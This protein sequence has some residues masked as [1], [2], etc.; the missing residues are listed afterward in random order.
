MSIRGVHINIDNLT[1]RYT[2]KS[3]LTFDNVRVEAKPGEALV[4]I[5][6]SGCGKSTL[7]HIIAGLMHAT[8][9]S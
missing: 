8:S 7:L 5:G 6:R 9:G 1:H 3:P 2:P 4:I